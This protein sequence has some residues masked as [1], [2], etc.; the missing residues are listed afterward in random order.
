MYQQKAD[1]ENGF[2]WWSSYVIHYTESDAWPFSCH[3]TSMHSWITHNS[4]FFILSYRMESQ[5]LNSNMF[6]FYVKINWQKKVKIGY[7]V[8]AQD[9][10]MSQWCFH[11][12]STLVCPHR[13]FG[14]RQTTS[15]PKN[16]QGT[17]NTPSR[18]TW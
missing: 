6:V 10:A 13:E 4:Y 17:C 5:W 15:G 1:K 3:L 9:Q 12:Q 14:R 8:E 18:T 11:E 16:M 2:S 7:Q